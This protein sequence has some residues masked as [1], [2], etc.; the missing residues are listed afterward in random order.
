MHPLWE[1]FLGPKQP[2]W[3]S[4]LSNLTVFGLVITLAEIYRRHTCK[5]CW[6]PAKHPVEGT[7]Y[8]TCHKHATCEVHDRLHSEHETKYPEQH[9]LLN[10][11]KAVTDNIQA[12]APRPYKTGRKPARHIPELNVANFRTAVKKDGAPATGDVS[13]GV[14]AWGMLGNDAEGDCVPAATEHNRISKGLYT[15]DTAPTTEKTLT[16]Y[17]RFGASQ[18]EGPDADEGCDIGTWLLWTYD[19]FEKA[20][21]AGDDIEEFAFA[22]VTDLSQG[23]LNAEM[24]TAKGIILGVSLTDDAQQLF[25]NSPWTVA[26]GE[27]PDPEEGHGILQVKYDDATKMAVCVSWG[28]LQQMTYDW[29]EACTEE[30]WIIYTREDAEQAGFDFDAAQAAIQALNGTVGVDPVDPS[31]GPVPAPEPSPE[32]PEPE[33]EPSPEPPSPEPEPEPTPPEPPIV[34]DI[35]K[36]LAV[37]ADAAVYLPQPIRSFAIQAL[38]RVEQLLSQHFGRSTTYQNE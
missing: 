13:Q 11:R 16:L 37:L 8:R 15:G 35:E 4:D 6:R 9:Q 24:L 2:I 23:S 27:Q 1:F 36:A 26:N 22:E 38:N 25:P 21:A 7:S 17:H 12:A 3:V 30:A 29:V 10:R 19:E 14:T 33:P 32:P 20:K 31:P 28:D 5:E 18:G 34:E